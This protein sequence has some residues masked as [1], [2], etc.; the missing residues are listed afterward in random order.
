MGDQGGANASCQSG[1]ECYSPSGIREGGV[2]VQT[3]ELGAA[4][5]EATFKWCK[6]KFNARLR[7]DSES[8]T[9]VPSNIGSLRDKCGNKE[10]GSP[11]GVQCYGGNECGDY[12]LTCFDRGGGGLDRR[13]GDNLFCGIQNRQP[14]E[15]CDTGVKGLSVLMKCATGSSCFMTILSTVGKCLLSVGEGEKCD[16]E[17]FIRCKFGYVCR[18]GTC[19]K[20]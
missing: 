16:Y 8:K 14:G 4:C 3:V 2:C 9:C 13:I 12:A 18:A 11:T 1:Y 6:G 10:D 19:V 20:E 7:C 5:D 15:D 17:G